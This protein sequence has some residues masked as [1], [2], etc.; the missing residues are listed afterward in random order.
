M[1]AQ[2]RALG[3][4]SIGDKDLVMNLIV[5]DLLEGSGVIGDGSP[6]LEIGWGTSWG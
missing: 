4:Y 5:R 1:A 6:K 3:V 2:T